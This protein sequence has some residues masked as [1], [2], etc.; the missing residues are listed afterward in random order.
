MGLGFLQD[1]E[2]VG[3]EGFEA[4]VWWGGGVGGG[5]EDCAAVAAGGEGEDSCAGKVGADFA[6]EQGEGQ[7]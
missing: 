6:R 3:G 1:V 4:V 5:D 2:S 7:R